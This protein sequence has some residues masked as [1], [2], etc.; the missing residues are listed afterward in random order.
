MYQQR[1]CLDFNL[2]RRW[3][4]N[5]QDFG[6]SVVK[7]WDLQSGFIKADVISGSIFS[8]NFSRTSSTESTV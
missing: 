7:W 4:W 3:Q 5:A 6:S 8:D 1:L 2:E